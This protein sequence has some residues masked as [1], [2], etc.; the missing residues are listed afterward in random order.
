MNLPLV[1]LK[2]W[3]I[4]MAGKLLSYLLYLSC[5]KLIYREKSNKVIVQLHGSYYSV[6]KPRY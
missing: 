3:R 5:A 2:Q 1:Q 4:A 6:I